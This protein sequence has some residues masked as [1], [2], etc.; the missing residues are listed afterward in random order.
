MMMMMMMTMMMI[1]IMMIMMQV[2]QTRLEKRSHRTENENC[3]DS[4]HI[5]IVEEVTMMAMMMM[6]TMTSLLVG[7]TRVTMVMIRII[8]QVGT[9][10]SNI[11][12]LNSKLAEAQEAK[13][14]L[15]AIK[16]KLE[17]VK[18]KCR[19]RKTKFLKGHCL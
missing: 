11:E 10:H 19:S 4:P 1:M 14:D 9:I 2:A 13:Q 5:K 6:M 12:H 3:N 16:H 15:L 18:G 17:Q 8:F 7:T